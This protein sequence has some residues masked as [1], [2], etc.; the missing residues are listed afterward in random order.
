VAH[1]RIFLSTVS[2][3]FLS[4]RDRLAEKLKRPNL[5]VHVQEDFIAAGTETLDKLDD[6]IRE[7]EAVVYL[8][9][10]MTGAMASPSDVAAITKRYPDLA[11]RCPPLAETLSTGTPA[12]SYT[13]WEAFLALYHYKIL[14]IAAPAP[15]APRDPSCRKVDA[16]ITAQQGHLQRLRSC[17]RYPEISFANADDLIIEVLRSKL[18][19]IL[20]QIDPVPARKP[21]SLPYASLGTLFKGRGESLKRLRDAFP[22][23]VDNRATTIVALHGL[24]GVGKTR[25]AI[26]YGWQHEAE[27]TALLLVSARTPELLNSNLAELVGP[28]I[29]DLPE[30]DA[31]DNEEKIKAALNWLDRNPRWLLILDN[32]D[33]AAAAAAAQALLP[34]LKGGDVLI[35]SRVA[36]FAAEIETLELDILDHG[37]ATAFLLERTAR[38]RRAAADDEVRAGDLAEQLGR[39]ALALEQAGAYIAHR[40]MSFARYIEEW[41]QHR[42]K[43]L[44]WFDPLVMRYG[45]SVAVTWQTSVA[46]LTDAARELLE[47]LAWLAPEPI[48]EFLL[49][50]AIPEGEIDEPHDALAGLAALSLVTR[51]RDQPQFSIHRLVQEVTRRRLAAEAPQSRLG[52]ALNWIYAGF[53]GDPDDVRT[54]PRLDPLAPH[55]LAVVQHADSAEITSPTARLMNQ[56]G[57]LFQT[58]ARYTEAEPLCRRALAILEKSFGPDHPNVATC[59][60]NLAELLTATNRHG[61]AEPLCRRALAIDEKSFGPDHP[62]VARGLNNLAELLRVTNRHA[63]AEQLS[64]RALAIAEKSFGLDHPNVAT[65]LNNLAGLLTATNRHGEA[66]PLCRRA[67]AIDEKSFGPDHPNVAIRLSNLAVLLEATNRYAE[68]EPLCRRALAILEESFGPDHPDVARGFGNLA[69][70]L[71]ATNRHAEAEPLYRRA[72]AIDEKSFGPDHPNVARGLNNLAELL[73]V[74]NRHAEA[75]P[76][77]R[78]ALAIDEKSFGPDHPNVARGLNNLAE[79][80]IATNRHGEAEQLSRRALAI[81]ENSF[82]PGHPNVATCLNN[83]AG[84]LTATNRHGEAEPLCRRALAIDEKSFGPDHPNVAIRL[85]ILAGLLTATNR[86]AEAEPLY[87]RALAILEENFGPGHPDVAT[88]SIT[89]PD[90]LTETNRHA[91]AETRHRCPRTPAA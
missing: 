91:E 60:N 64:R 1:A 59:L 46:Q 19:D 65:C 39:L 43:A 75:E 6:Y 56:L 55:A 82:G 3:E 7:C 36:N 27:Y 87:R 20:R 35:T 81:A 22:G 78:R 66:E 58:Q 14:I 15:E 23:G 2:D 72:L 30:K 52:E 40:R 47:L 18:Q 48:P 37:A 76:L 62:N 77:S 50:V 89:S 73:R 31:R 45:A 42:E 26:E 9:G 85:S 11:T 63:E 34:R 13:Q 68:A 61:E 28:L 69:V 57:V 88:A 86:R 29:L 4:Y 74:T 8:V 54:W 53:A 33:D 16:E 71:E 83:L 80:L 70:L 79:L 67:L 32:I 84:L 10:D 24:G 41:Q 25:L 90:S 38:H 12:L 49:D 5:S 51:D 21:N 44:A 17:H